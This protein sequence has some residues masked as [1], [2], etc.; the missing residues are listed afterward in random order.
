M[1]RS[2]RR[3]S[4]DSVQPGHSLRSPCLLCSLDSTHSLHW[5]VSLRLPV[6]LRSL[7]LLCLPRPAPAQAA[8]QFGWQ[9]CLPPALAA[10]PVLPPAAPA[11]RQAG[12]VLG[13][14]QHPAKRPAL[15]SILPPV[16][17][18]SAGLATHFARSARLVHF[19]RP[20]PFALATLSLHRPAKPSARSPP[21]LRQPPAR[22]PWPAASFLAPFAVQIG[23]APAQPVARRSASPHPRRA[24]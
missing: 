19:V 8:H 10:R 3:N 13:L 24:A 23:L 7:C 16:P 21:V 12:L 5:E 17:A 4:Q 1:R 6:P 9:P 14:A 22:P 2:L 20:L 15:A 18:P 11:S